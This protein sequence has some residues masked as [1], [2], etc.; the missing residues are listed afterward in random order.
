MKHKAY[1]KIMNAINKFGLYFNNK[2]HR[3][4][5]TFMK[6]DIDIAALELRCYCNLGMQES[7]EMAP[8]HLEHLK[9]I[10]EELHYKKQ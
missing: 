7:Y 2:C 3:Y 9:E 6:N 1:R 4:A 10:E 5:K 8:A